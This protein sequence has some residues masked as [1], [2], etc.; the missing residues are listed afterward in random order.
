MSIDLGSSELY[1][2]ED[3]EA[4]V[5][6]IKCKFAFWGNCELKNIR[7]AGDDASTDEKLAWVNELNPD[8]GYTQ[9]AEFLMDFHTPEDVGNLTLNADSDYNDYQWWL[10]RTDD[11]GWEIASFGY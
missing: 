2:Q 4:A 3:L 9:V 7:Y 10:A 8:S 5:V 6:Q 1:S 11:S